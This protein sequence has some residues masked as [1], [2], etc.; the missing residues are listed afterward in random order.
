MK[1]ENNSKQA[2]DKSKQDKDKEK[3]VKVKVR[4][5]DSQY[6]RA[7]GAL[8]LFVEF[9]DGRRKTL[10][11]DKS[12]FTCRHGNLDNEMEKTAPMFINKRINLDMSESEFEDGKM[13][14]KISPPSLR[15]DD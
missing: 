6:L 2:K 13:L 14:G 8:C 1:S 9:P 3:S 4:V 5:L 15:S 7:T 11:I 12:A 10:S